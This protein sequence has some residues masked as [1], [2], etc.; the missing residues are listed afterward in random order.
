L[1]LQGDEILKVKDF[2]MELFM[3]QHP[4]PGDFKT[5]ASFSSNQIPLDQAPHKVYTLT[6]EQITNYH[7]DGFLIVRGFFAVDEAEVLQRSL[8]TDIHAYERGEIRAQDNS[9]KV[10]SIIYWT[11]LGDSLLGIFPRVSRM[12]E[13]AEAL[14]GEPCY[15][16][17]SKI[18]RKLPQSGQV[19]WHQD[20]GSWYHD[21]CLTPQLISCAI[22]IESCTLSNG[23]LQMLKGSHR[24]GRMDVT[25]MGNTVGADPQRVKLALEHFELVNCEME[26]GDA[27]FFHSNVLHGSP[28]NFSDRSRAMMF[29]TYNVISNAPFIEEGQ[30]HHYYR[31]LHKVPD[32]AIRDKAYQSIFDDRCEVY[33][34]D[35]KLDRPYMN[36]HPISKQ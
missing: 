17:H 16:W 26:S 5:M 4:S 11:E 32:T 13:G 6:Q 23:C 24:L 7:Q 3:N 2:A 20:Y 9:G 1:G 15:H 22:A 19:E 14:L 18:C 35:P 28:P 34:P 36:I 33:K 8:E 30:Q 21:G 10:Y 31:P 27:V 25:E 12:V 29:C